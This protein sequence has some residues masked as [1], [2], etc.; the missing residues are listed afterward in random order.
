MDKR[1]TYC[2]KKIT[3]AFINDYVCIL[4][5]DN[6]ATSKGSCEEAWQWI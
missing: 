6:F 5:M 4:T 1:K 3:H 2:K